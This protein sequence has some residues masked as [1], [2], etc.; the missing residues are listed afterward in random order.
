LM[1]PPSWCP[2]A[3]PPVRSSPRRQQPA[4]QRPRRRPVG[5]KLPPPR[6]IVRFSCRSSERCSLSAAGT[7]PFE[8]R[9]E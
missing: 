7:V 5:N 1:A 3:E 6:L 4:R 9:L 2:A 8:V